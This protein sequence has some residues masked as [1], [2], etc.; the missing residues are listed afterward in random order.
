MIRINI[1]QQ[2]IAFPTS[3]TDANWAAGVVA[4]AQAVASQLAS[5]AS[6]FDISPRVQI[7]TSDANTNLNISDVVFPSG[8]VR[9]FS[10]NYAIYRTN[11]TTSLAETGFVN[12]VYDS[13]SSTWNLEQEF[14]GNRQTD[15]SLFHTFSM[16]G[17]QLQLTTVAMGGAYDNTT[18]KISYAAKTILVN[19]I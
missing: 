6:Q 5:V 9:S 3:G 7:L 11:A 18:S 14:I 1:G 10:F 2:T 13:L 15:G 12:G 8:S 19:D 17:D 16:N 4:F